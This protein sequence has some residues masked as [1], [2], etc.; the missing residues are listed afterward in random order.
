MLSER[1]Q[2][3][4]NFLSFY[5]SEAQ[6]LVNIVSSGKNQYSDC[7]VKPKLDWARS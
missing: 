3:Q 5:V 1:H 7:L 6:E 4:Y 2:T